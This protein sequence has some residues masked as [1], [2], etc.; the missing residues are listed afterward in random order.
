YGGTQVHINSD[1]GDQSING[2]A[3]DILHFAGIKDAYE[4]GAHDAKGNRT[5]TPSPGYDNTNIMTSRDGTNL[6]PEQ[7]DQAKENKSTKK[8]TVEDQKP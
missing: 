5:S 4:E 1:F 2:A 3:H 8:V 7:L 6:K